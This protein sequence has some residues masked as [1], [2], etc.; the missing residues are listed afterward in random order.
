[1]AGLGDHP[2]DLLLAVGAS[3]DVTLHL[4]ARAALEAAGD[5]GLQRPGFGTDFVWR[6][7]RG[8]LLD[9]R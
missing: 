3:V 7:S 9:Q 2:I 4:A 8:G 1:M 6:L 5:E